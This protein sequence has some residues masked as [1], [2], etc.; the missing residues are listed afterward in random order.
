[1]PAITVK[2]IPDE[3]YNLLKKSAKMNHRSIN[4]EIIYCIEHRLKSHKKNID[5]IL[6]SASRFREKTSEYKLTEKELNR[7]KT[8]GR[9]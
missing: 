7:A 3:L 2:N 8:N 1:M 4:S 9:P 6:A 5:D